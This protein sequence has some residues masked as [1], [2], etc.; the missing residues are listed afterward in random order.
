MT[1]LLIVLI[2]ACV[3][4]TAYGQGV[5]IPNLPS[6][7]ALSGSE[8]IPAVQSGAAVRLTPAQIQAFILG[9][10]N[11]FTSAPVNITTGSGSASALLINSTGDS[12][13]GQA[14]LGFDSSGNTY[15]YNTVAGVGAFFG[16]NVAGTVG[17]VTGGS[18]RLTIGTNG[19]VTVSAPT[20][21]N[22]LTI[23]TVS[24]G[25]GI[26]ISGPTSGTS[27]GETI[28]AG[29]SHSDFALNIRNA[30]STQT[31][32]YV[33]GDGT[34]QAPQLPAGGGVTGYVCW[35]SSG[36]TYDTVAACPASSERFK[37]SIKALNW[38]LGEVEGLRSVSY[39]LK[40]QYDPQYHGKREQLGFLA[41]EVAKVDPRLVEFGKDGKPL[42]V[43]YD[44]VTVLLVK[45]LQ[46]EHRH[47]LEL[48]A[49]QVV[50]F[51]WLIFLTWRTRRRAG[52]H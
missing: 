21:G 10:A 45:A 11:T 42:T 46:E 14:K 16:S 28:N 19:N 27:L 49:S 2:L 18:S 36:L 8:Q 13:N 4:L 26:F 5:T 1:R 22:T 52:A 41:E 30:A 31:L 50:T 44:R 9:S 33:A 25:A 34:I 39:R 43:I 35:S 12:T 40:P 17:L 48:A 15:L 24:G 7:S 51:L 32:F 20:S 47:V 6:A 37:R 29:T 23:N 3:S 38:A